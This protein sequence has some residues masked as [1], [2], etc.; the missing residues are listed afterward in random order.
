MAIAERIRAALPANRE[1]AM[2]A[3]LIIAAL[4][5]GEKV[6]VYSGSHFNGRKRELHNTAGVSQAEIII[7][8]AGIRIQRGND[9]PRGGE[10]GKYISL[11]RKNLRIAAQVMVIFGELYASVRGY[12]CRLYDEYGREKDSKWGDEK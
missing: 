12:P 1:W 7:E 5:R 11:P 6:H 8:K 10:L 9:A 2:N 3:L 4:Y